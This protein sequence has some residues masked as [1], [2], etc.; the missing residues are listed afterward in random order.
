MA[1][2][3]DRARFSDCLDTLKR[4]SG[5]SYQALAAK[6]HISR[7]SVHRFCSGLAVPQEFGT[8]EAIALAC[9]ATRAEIDT[10]YRLWCRAL[11]PEVPCE[12]PPP[13][14]TVPPARRPVRWV[15]ISAGVVLVAALL[16]VLRGGSPPEQAAARV[17]GAWSQ[18]PL[19]VPPS[20]F[21]V[22]VGNSSGAMP[23]FR[24]GAARFWDSHTR[25]AN[26]EPRRG[27]FDWSV[28]DRLVAG[29]EARGM[30][31]LYT[32]GG[33]P[34]WASPA[35]P[36][37]VYDDGSRTTPPDDLGD[38]DGYVRAV[39]ERYRGRI[40]AYELWVFGNDTRYYSGDVETLAEMTRRANRIIKEVSRDATVVC[41]GMGRLWQEDARAV[42]ERFAAT[43]AY[44]H[45][46]AAGIK[47]HQKKASDP[48]ESMLE[49]T[50]FVESTFHRAGVHPPLW[51]TGTTYELPLNDPLDPD[52]GADYAV[53]FYLVGLYARIAR[54]YFYN[55]GGTKLPVVLQPVGGDPTRAALQVEELQRWLNRAAIESCAQGTPAGLPSG[56]YQCRFRSG[57]GKPLAVLWT[58]HG[59]AS[60]PTPPAAVDVRRLDG[61]S[62][63]AD[64][65]SDL[66]ITTRPILVT[67]R[68][69]D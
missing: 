60:M 40:Q 11:D 3:G 58:D 62:T 35:G 68:Q 1:P 12:T 6:T 27:E 61:S 36:R 54:M 31:V 29:A 48:P 19:A 56:V 25:W 20:F 32:F 30:P 13:P 14:T 53:R 59:T 2:T 21:G 17:A 15:A 63:P 52:I 26:V 57:D 42:L 43:R 65:A 9:G 7:S 49:L 47:L 51:S 46:D 55:W 23:T 5:L 45:C 22:T 41:P 67:F 28:L 34:E 44:D 18:A 69:T 38:W 16:V 66:T 37:A 50:D 33:T 8:V 64:A 4:R 10:L 39:A 24:I